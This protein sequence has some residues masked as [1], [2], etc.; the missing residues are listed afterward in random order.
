MATKKKPF[1]DVAKTAMKKITKKLT[2][3]VDSSPPGKSNEMPTPVAKKEVTMPDFQS[4]IPEM[5]GM[6][7]KLL[8]Q[9]A[10]N[11]VKIQDVW[12]RAEDGEFP[13]PMQNVCREAR[14]WLKKQK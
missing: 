13:G 8:G 9:A 1:K 4:S 5:N 12:N 6:G 11:L 14:D 7:M 3:G 10:R 2:S